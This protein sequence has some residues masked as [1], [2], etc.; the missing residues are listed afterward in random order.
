MNIG[1]KKILLL[2]CLISILPLSASLFSSDLV[3]THDGL[4]HLPRIGAFY[5]ALLEGQFP[6]RWAGDLNYGYGM[7]LFIFIYHVPYLFSSI[8]LLIGLGLVW[9]FKLSLLISFLLSGIGMYLFAQAFFKDQKKAFLITLLYQFAPFHLIDLTIRASFGEIYTY[10]FLPFV[11]YF[12]TRY[13]QTKNA[14]FL[15]LSSVAVSFLILSHNSISLLFFGV[16]M[17]FIFFFSRTR[18]IL[19]YSLFSLALGLMLSA[20]YWLPALMEHKYTY[21]D[22]FMKELYRERFPPLWK[23]FIPNFFDTKSLQIDNIALQLGVFHVAPLLLGI[24][25]LLKKFSLLLIISSFFFMSDLSLLFWENISFLRQFQFPWRFLSV[26]V[27]ATSL[28][29]FIYVKFIRK[30]VYFYLISFLIIFSSMTYWFPKEG[31]DQIKE[32]YYWNFPLN[33]TYYGETDVIWSAGPAK[34]YPK[35]RISVIEGRGEVWGL[36]KRSNFQKFSV[37][38]ETDIKLVSN[39][40]YFP[41]WRVY[42]DGVSV[43]IQFQNEHYRGLITFPVPKG[44]HMVEIK[45]EESKLR[46]AADVISVVGVLFLSLTVILRKKIS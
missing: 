27:F 7:P 39:T 40:Q 12:L 4:V 41:G 44:D 17:C 10:A 31:Y 21:G 28:L 46:F 13:S 32:S 9:S 22:L 37:S 15:A 5:K 14:G 24:W 19:V 6:V 1:M 2:I 11:L 38:A 45:L 30:T 36:Q 26:V 20:F 35:E 25:M 43:P 16:S 3:H 34:S 18:R 42:V 29:G 8:F 23:F 33:S